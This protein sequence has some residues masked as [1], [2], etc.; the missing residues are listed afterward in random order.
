MPI[1]SLS[2]L[3]TFFVPAVSSDLAERAGEAHP[4]E[5]YEITYL[6]YHAVLEVALCTEGSGVCVVEGVEYPFRA[7]DVQIIFP[8]Q[9]HLSRSAP[10]G[11]KWLWLSLYPLRLLS[12]WNPGCAP[13]MEALLQ[14]RMGLCGILDRQRHP[15][16]AQLIE[17]VVRPGDQALRL[18]CLA[19][20]IEVLAEES[21]GMA[22]LALRPE[23]EFLHLE[24]ALRLSEERLAAGDLPCVEEM[25]ALCAMPP[26]SFRRAFHRVMGQSPRQYVQACQVR[27]AQHLL[28]FTDLGVTDIAL[29]VGY[30][31][32]S[33]FNRLFLHQC[34]LTPREYRKRYR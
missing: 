29:S 19:A 23:Q 33:G 20:L 12:L 26:A 25:A 32:A 18:A 34:G 14:T 28:L 2:E 7:G 16:A 24:P 5:V 6:H 9:R 11:S 30:Q 1:R 8:F 22:P 13:R 21:R 15:L 31:D 17:R 4:L 10:Q 3:P 27:R